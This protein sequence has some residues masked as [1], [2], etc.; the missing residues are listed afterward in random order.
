[1]SEQEVQSSVDNLISKMPGGII[2]SGV[3]LKA[4][5][6]LVSTSL[7]SPSGSKTSRRHMDP[8]VLNVGQRELKKLWEQQRTKGRGEGEQLAVMQKQ[9]RRMHNLC[10]A[11]L[12]V[13][14]YNYHQ[15]VLVKCVKTL[16]PQ[17]SLYSWNS[18]NP[19]F[20][21]EDYCRMLL[22]AGLE[23]EAFKAQ[24]AQA[25]AIQDQR[26]KELQQ[27][28][29]NKI[30]QIDEKQV[31]KMDELEQY[32]LKQRADNEQRF[33]LQRKEQQII[34]LERQVGV[35]RTHTHTHTVV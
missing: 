5:T 1:M 8:N 34:E 7:I 11:L 26:R 31:A 23:Q 33:A 35:A 15:I 16:P 25:Q 3:P 30:Q 4:T 9:V 18:Q 28:Q 22:A 6:D 14:L 10:I 32:R 27:Q 29:Q 12:F 20:Q 19:T 2:K 17:A 21:G 13:C 24:L